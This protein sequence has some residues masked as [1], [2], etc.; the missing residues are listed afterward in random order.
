[1]VALLTWRRVRPLPAPRLASSPGD[2]VVLSIL[3]ARHAVVR[4]A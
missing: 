2:A 1:V 4:P 3:W